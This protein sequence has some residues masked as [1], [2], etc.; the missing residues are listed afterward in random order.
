MKTQW[1]EP[2]LKK[3]NLEETKAVEPIIMHKYDQQNAISLDPYIGWKCPCCGK[4]SGYI[5]EVEDAARDDFKTNHINS[6]PKY[7]KTTERCIS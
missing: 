1:N 2:Q 3:L 6:C 4:E 5:F 7:D